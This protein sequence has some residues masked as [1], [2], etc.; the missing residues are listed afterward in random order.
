MQIQPHYI[1]FSCQYLPWRLLKAQTLRDSISCQEAPRSSTSAPASQT[2]IPEGHRSHMAHR[3]ITRCLMEILIIRFLVYL[4]K[5]LYPS[6]FKHP[7]PSF[8]P[9]PLSWGNLISSIPQLIFPPTRLKQTWNVSFNSYILQYI[10]LQ[11]R[12]LL[13]HNQIEVEISDAFWLSIISQIMS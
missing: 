2:A 12:T 1:P 13:P 11:D 9:R 5:N 6:H 8:T 3:R 10:T 4:V 7:H